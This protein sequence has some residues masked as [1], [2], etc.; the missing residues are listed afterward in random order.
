MFEIFP[1][2]VL[3]EAELGV[4]EHQDMWVLSQV[5]IVGWNLVCYKEAVPIQSF[6]DSMGASV[7]PAAKS[8]A[9]MG[10][11]RENVNRQGWNRILDENPW[12]D[13][14]DLPNAQPRGEPRRPRPR[15]IRPPSDNA[16]DDSGPHHEGDNEEVSDDLLPAESGA[17]S[18]EEDAGDGDISSGDDLFDLRGQLRWDV[19]Q[20]IFFH[21]R[22]MGGPWL[23]RTRGQWADRVGAFPRA[24]APTNWAEEFG[25]PPQFSASANH[26]GGWEAVNELAREWC[27]RW[28]TLYP[29]GANLG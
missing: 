17:E 7:R 3:T 22:V 11:R 19:D 6:F 2:R 12:L 26:Y 24:G 29:M 4:Q 13:E 15:V 16:S 20:Q 9:G 1:L 5:R 25:W 27:R 14:D 28:P 18:M 8:R 21:I 23:R 10:A